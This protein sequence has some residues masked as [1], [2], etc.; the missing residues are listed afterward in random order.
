MDRVRVNVIVEN[1]YVQ[2]DPEE[3]EHLLLKENIDQESDASATT[4]DQKFNKTP[5]GR[6]DVTEKQLRDGNS[7]SKRGM[8]PHPGFH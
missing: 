6:T 8:A 1:I 5:N 3:R 4:M 2:V 7:V